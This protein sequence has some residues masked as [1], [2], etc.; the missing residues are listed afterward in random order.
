MWECI[1]T[2]TIIILPTVSVWDPKMHYKLWLPWICSLRAWRRLK[3]ESKRVV[4]NCI[5][6]NKLL[7][8]DWY[9]Y[10][11]CVCAKQ[12]CICHSRHVNTLYRNQELCE[13]Q[14]CFNKQDFNLYAPCILYIRTGVSLLS[15][16]RFLYI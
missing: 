16:E 14:F 8:F 13:S 2:L 12:Q 4:L 15:R 10:T 1:C 5:L 7:C 6:G 9:F 11:V 3:R